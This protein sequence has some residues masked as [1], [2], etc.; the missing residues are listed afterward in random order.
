[1]PYAG[2]G[3]LPGDR[4]AL[5]EE[6]ELE[7]AAAN[8][9]VLVVLAGCGYLDGAEIGEAVS[10]LL[11]LDLAGARVTIAA[12]DQPQRHVVN[13]RTG[14]ETGE[15]RN[16]LDEA[17]RIVRGKIVPLSGVDPAAFDAVFLPGGF[18]AAKNLSDLALRG[19]EATVIPDLVRVL[20]AFRAANKPIGAVCISP[21]VVVAALREGEVTIGDDVGTAGA[22]GQM[23]GSHVA[24]GVSELHVDRAHKL[25]TAPAYMYGEARLSAVYAGISKAV[26]AVLELS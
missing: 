4:G 22:I 9:H 18:G 16:V 20:R 25:V 15:T 21:A 19:P 24:C 17:A 6:D 10:T 8:K 23:G 3:W 1:M 26:S 11:A 2:G 7:Q 14:E 13:H 5:S 12:P